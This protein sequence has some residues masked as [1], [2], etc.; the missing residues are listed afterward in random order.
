MNDRRKTPRPTRLGDPRTSPYDRRLHAGIL[1]ILW[2]PLPTLF[3][4]RITLS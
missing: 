2:I 4:R 1:R 3:K